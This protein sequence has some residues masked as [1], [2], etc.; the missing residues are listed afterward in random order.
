MWYNDDR[1]S[2]PPLFSNVIN[3]Q[4]GWWMKVMSELLSIEQETSFRTRYKHCEYVVISFR[5]MKTP[6]IFIDY[7]NK[8]FHPFL[9][10][11]VVVF[12]NDISI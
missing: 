11:F 4:E 7:M 10:K 6:N 12:I 2:M 9:D 5:V 3:E 1:A 8:I